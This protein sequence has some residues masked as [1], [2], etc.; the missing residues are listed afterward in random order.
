MFIKLKAKS[1]HLMYFGLDKVSAVS[2]CSDFTDG[3]HPRF[4][5]GMNGYSIDCE[6]SQA[7]LD[8]LKLAFIIEKDYQLVEKPEGWVEP[9]AEVN[10]LTKLREM[11]L[12]AQPKPPPLDKEDIN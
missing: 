6:Y 5:I 7:N 9:E 10:P 2:I 12:E 1:G 11:M 3:H 8:A 4:E